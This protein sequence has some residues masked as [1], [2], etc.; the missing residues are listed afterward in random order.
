MFD[1]HVHTA[2]DVQARFGDDAEIVRLYERAG[3]SGCVLKGHY[4]ATAGRARAAGRDSS[5]RV[6]GALALNQHVGGL[7]PAAVAAALAMGA[8]V[9][10]MPTTDSHTQETAGLPRLCRVMPQLPTTTYAIPPVDRSTE[11][12][13]RQIVDLIAEADAVL[14][15]GHLS[16]AETA[17]L[18]PVAR[19]A[20]V[21]RLL[22]THPGYTVPAM[23]ATEAAELT[24]QG[25]YAEITAFQL[26]HQRGCSASRLA[27]FVRAVGTDRI[28]LSSD[29]GQPD[30]PPPP[31]ALSEL[32]EALAGEG[33]DRGALTACASELPE[34]L[35]TPRPG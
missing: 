15:T 13:V 27:E 11:S 18:L 24:A 35:V 31:E 7:N 16:T 19:A 1:L 4:D 6:Y 25:A 2:P 33:L 26:L 28:V 5:V 34:R 22:I 23:S 20:G 12:G 3:F 32:L 14:A 29:A 8:R 9:I 30:S 21:R 17:W 10:W